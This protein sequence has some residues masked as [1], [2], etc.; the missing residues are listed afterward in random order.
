VKLRTLNVSRRSRPR[1]PW[2]ALDG[3]SLRIQRRAQVG[4]G[5]APFVALL[6]W[7]TNIDK[8]LPIH[9]LNL[10]GLQ[11]NVMSNTRTNDEGGSESRRCAGTGALVHAMVA[12]AAL[13]FVA[14]ALLHGKSWKDELIQ[15]VTAV[16]PEADRSVWNLENIKAG[17][18]VMVLAQDG[19]LGSISTDSRYYGTDVK[20]GKLST[21]G[22][23]LG[24]N[25][26]LLK[27][28]QRVVLT[29]VKIVEYQGPTCFDCS[30]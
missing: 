24:R 16:Y 30:S 27:K 29:S 12:V 5:K 11:E 19:A 7:N 10:E 9:R 25:S 14:P 6:N 26:Q 17:G 20:D 8:L 18:K 15:K 22:A 2:P 21:E 23:P 13:M 4:V 1:K 3:S 28:G